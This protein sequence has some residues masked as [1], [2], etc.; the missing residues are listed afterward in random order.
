MKHYTFEKLDV[1]KKSRDLVK[2]IYQITKEFPSE[3][4]YGLTSQI[5]RAVISIS[6]NLAEGTSRQ[7]LKDQ[8]RF[9]IMAYG[10]LMEV[11][12]QLILAEDLEYINNDTLNKIR[13]LIEEISNKLNKL[14]L[15]QQKRMTK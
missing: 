13:P 12:N 10:S 3:E 2:I 6:S 9:S 5:R 8:A 15:S 7:S 14:T 1:W 11:L 4:K